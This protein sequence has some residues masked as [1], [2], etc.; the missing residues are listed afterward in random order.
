MTTP[1][2]RHSFDDL[3]A[4]YGL[5][6][7]GNE[8]EPEFC[9][10]DTLVFDAGESVDHDGSLEGFTWRFDDGVVLEGQRVERRF[11]SS[12]IERSKNTNGSPRER[13]A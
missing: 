5:T 6:Y 3:S 1:A 9:D 13:L 8:F 11:D 2:L 7:S 10:G 12:D 4:T